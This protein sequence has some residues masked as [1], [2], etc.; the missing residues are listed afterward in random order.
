MGKF[1]HF[2]SETTNRAESEHP[3]LKA[4]I[5]TRHGNLDTIFLKIDTLIEGQITE[6]KTTLEYSRLK[7]KDNDKSNLVIA[8]L[9]WDCIKLP[10]ISYTLGHKTDSTKTDKSHWEYIQI[11][12]ARMKASSKSGSRSDSELGSGAFYNFVYPYIVDWKNVAEV[13]NYGFRV[14]SYFLYSNENQWPNVHRQ[15][16]NE[17]HRKRDMYWNFFGDSERF[18]NILRSY[19]H[20]VRDTVVIGHL[21]DSEHFI[22]VSSFFI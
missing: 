19:T 20:Q 1:L 16:W 3:L 8:Q 21:A 12:H 7:E 9:L 11:A 14:L 6:I 13:G 18:Y 10:R 5:A 15:M 2:G 22:A 4:W 17:M